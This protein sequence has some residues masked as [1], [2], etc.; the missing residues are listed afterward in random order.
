MQLYCSPE[1][2]LL[3]QYPSSLVKLQANGFVLVPTLNS[4]SFSIVTPN[5]AGRCRVG[6]LQIILVSLEELPF[7]ERQ[8]ALVGT[9]LWEAV[10][11]L[12]A[13][14]RTDS[15]TYLFSGYSCSRLALHAMFKGWRQEKSARLGQRIDYVHLDALQG[16][17]K[18]HALYSQLCR[19]KNALL[20]EGLDLVCDKFQLHNH[21]K[22]YVPTTKNLHDFV[23]S[24][25]EAPFIVKPCGVGAYQGKGITIVNNEDD[26]ERAQEIIKTHKQWR[27]IVCT[28][29]QNPL[30]FYKPDGQGYKF[31]LRLYMLI[32]S[33]G[34]YAVFP[35]AHIFTAVAP[36]QKDDYTRA[37]TDSHGASTEEDWEFPTHYPTSFLQRQGHGAQSI[38]LLKKG[39]DNVC[40]AIGTVLQN[41]VDKY[42]ESDSAYEIIAPD[43]LFDQNL[44]P[45]LLEVNR[46]VGLASQAQTRE[47]YAQWTAE[48]W[49]WVYEQGI[50]PGL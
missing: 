36:Y 39:I 46:K 27:G 28:Y 24:A 44:Q 48:F 25:Q 13:P 16:G 20:A 19:C 22:E 38:N 21:L 8:G 5:R 42:S 33:H 7:W 26:L 32:T 45:W 41:N 12:C 47:R 50:L 43:V 1:I 9:F 34:T 49:R 15:G 23:F 18:E 17:Q 31:H 35:R 14:T 37:R 6:H 29:I 4:A 30:L 3:A 10:D 11:Y 40:A 2:K